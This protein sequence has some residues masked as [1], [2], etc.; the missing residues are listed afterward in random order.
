MKKKD[1]VRT[2][3]ITFGYVLMFLAIDYKLNGF[4]NGRYALILIIAGAGL[5]LYEEIFWRKRQVDW[6]L[7]FPA[8]MRTFA[9]ILL[10][11]G[12]KTYLVQYVETQW[13]WF[14]VAGFFIYNYHHK[15]VDK[16]VPGETND[17][18]FSG[19]LI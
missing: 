17:K 11:L 8:V 13:I 10:F 4:L 14:I 15:I 5:L 6:S 16:L 3:V 7:G 12:L 18:N 2:L 19:G 9:Y 1:L